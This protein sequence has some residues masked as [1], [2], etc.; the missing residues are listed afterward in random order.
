MIDGRAAH[1]E[2]RGKG[3][4]IRVRHAAPL[5]GGLAQRERQTGEGA[6]RLEAADGSE[7]PVGGLNRSREIRLLRVEKPVQPRLHVTPN[8]LRLELQQTAIRTHQPKERC[9]LLLPLQVD[10]P[11]AAPSADKAVDPQRAQQLEEHPGRSDIAQHEL[12][13]RPRR[14][15]RDRA[16]AEQRAA[17]E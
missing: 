15:E 8:A 4:E 11:A 2:G 17:Q 3:I 14:A 12:D 1:A 13:V 7:L 9:D 10:D 5:R 16:T 6:L